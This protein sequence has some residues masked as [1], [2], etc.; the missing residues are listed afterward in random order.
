MPPRPDPT[1]E[2]MRSFLVR[3]AMTADVVVA[4][5][6]D[7]LLS[8]AQRM[9][10][11]RVSGLPVVGPHGGVVGVLSER[12]IAERLRT[13]A[14]VLQARGLLDLVVEAADGRTDRIAQCT[15]TLKG[16]RVG[17]V[18]TRHPVTI[19]PDEPL[20]EAARWLQQAG[21][22]RL[23]VVDGQKLVGIVTRDD[24]V[25]MAAPPQAATQVPRRP[26]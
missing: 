6:D 26:G 21:I 2:R 4:R 25:R 1:Y 24:L 13:A 8:A 19:E 7:T 12:D 16:T 22:H 15:R 9:R 23:P 14:G 17:E 18:M 5:L 3:D 11:K 20:S 10:D